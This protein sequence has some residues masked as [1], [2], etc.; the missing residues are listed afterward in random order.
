MLIQPSHYSSSQKG[1]D[2]AKFRALEKKL[3]YEDL[4]FYRSLARSRLR[5]DE[6]LRKIS[7]EQKLKDRGAKQS[8]SSW[9]WGS[10]ASTT[11]QVDVFRGEM[12]DEQRKQLYDVLDY[13]EKEAIASTLK[14]PRESLKS[15]LS[16]KLRT[17]SFSLRMD[18]HSDPRDI[19]S[20]VFDSFNAD[21]LQRPESLEATLSLDA[22][23]VFDG[24]TKNTVHS[25][26]VRVKSSLHAH[27]RQEN[28]EPFFLIKYENNP[29]DRRADN[30][31]TLRM[32]HME[33][34]YHRGYIQAVY[35]FFE[36]PPSQLESVE[37]LLV[38]GL[39]PSFWVVTDLY[40]GRGQPNSGRFTKRN[41]CWA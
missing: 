37:A 20:I 32:R 5:K 35:K 28:D 7:E 40:Q 38:C 3:S 13:D 4:R 10:P 34:I 22:F 1:Q 6:A 27:K 41:S 11:E 14:L 9:L 15:R 39:Y 26:I 23:K 8:W 2:I 19:L 12:T 33:V 25:Q 24:T 18:P 36:P 16:A 21:V 31:L 29:L 30:A 17:G